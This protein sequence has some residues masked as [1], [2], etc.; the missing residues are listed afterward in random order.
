VFH[1]DLY[2]L[3]LPV[4]PA[5]ERL[6]YSTNAPIPTTGDVLSFVVIPGF[7]P[8]YV[9]ND[10]LPLYEQPAAQ[11][12]ARSKNYDTA[13]S[14]IMAARNLCAGVHDQVINGVRY[15][16]LSPRQDPYDLPVDDAGRARVA[17]NVLAYKTR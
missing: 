17:F 1:Q 14:M 11:I 6:V 8:E 2:T 3:L 10:P 15:V 7:P 9:H 5:P 13:M 16:Y 4:A 12:V